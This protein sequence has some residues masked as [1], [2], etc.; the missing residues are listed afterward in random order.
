MFKKLIVFLGILFLSVACKQKIKSTNPPEQ[1]KMDKEQQSISISNQGFPE[2]VLPEQIKNRY[3]IQNSLYVFALQPN[4]NNYLP[5]LNNRKMLWHGVLKSKDEGKIWSKFFIILDPNDP[6]EKNRK[7]KYNPVGVFA[8]KESIYVDIANDRGAGSGEGQLLRFKTTDE[9]KTWQKVGCF[10]FIPE[11][12]YL[13]NDMS[14]I[15]PNNLKEIKDAC[16]Y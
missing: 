12:Y 1:I 16:V 13:Q 5:S 9:G 8:E 11:N 3:L 14:K 7:I 6:A 10:Y 4:A 15:D 2:D